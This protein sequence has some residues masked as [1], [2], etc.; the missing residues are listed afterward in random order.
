ML[1]ITLKNPD[2]TIE[3]KYLDDDLAAAL[4]YVEKQRQKPTKTMYVSGNKT[5]RRKWL[6][7][8]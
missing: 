2:K 6:M 7:S 3:R 8:R 1:S 5:V 4:N